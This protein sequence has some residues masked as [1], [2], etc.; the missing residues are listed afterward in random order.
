M[1]SNFPN[2]S[3]IWI[4]F[5][6][7]IQISIKEKWDTFPRLVAS[8]NTISS[9]TKQFS[10]SPCD[11]NRADVLPSHHIPSRTV[12]G[13]QMGWSCFARLTFTHTVKV[14]ACEKDRCPDHIIPRADT[15][16]V[17]HKGLQSCC[18]VSL[19]AL[20]RLHATE[21]TAHFQAISW[22]VPQWPPPTMAAAS[23]Q[24]LL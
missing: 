20:F 5:G 13:V 16:T 7:K 2:L 24:G 19:G 9:V 21:V 3:R 8:R 4:E 6:W 17:A 11:W 14:W 15:H 1:L 22:Q 18:L 12:T 23:G 10:T